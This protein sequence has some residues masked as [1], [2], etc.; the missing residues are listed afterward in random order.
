MRQ[1]GISDY[2]SFAKAAT[3]I[4]D[5]FPISF[6]VFSDEPSEM[7]RQ[8]KML[9]SL[10]SNIAVKV[11][12]T[13]SGGE[14][15]SGVVKELSASGIR[16]NVTAV[17]SKSQTESVLDALS[18]GPGGYVSVFAGRI[19]D[20]GV[21]PI[22]VVADCLQLLKDLPQVEV[23]WA[24]PRE[25]LNIVQADQ[26]GCH[27]ITVTADL[28]RKIDGLGKNLDQFSLETVQMFANDARSAGYSL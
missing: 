27:V 8:A 12:I 2:F 6:E 13:N 9:A 3:E 14:S 22:P 5:G 26:C 20:A 24:S 23:I 7:V 1:A 18:K 17:F 28:V 16:V 11:P 19:A 10:G 4:V 15:S 21:D 25:V